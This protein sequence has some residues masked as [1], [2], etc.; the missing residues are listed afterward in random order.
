MAINGKQRRPSLLAE[1]R[2]CRHDITAAIADAA[3]LDELTWEQI[4]GPLL[5]LVAGRLSVA[6]GDSDDDA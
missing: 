1:L 5:R 6:A 4:H 3:Q 2:A